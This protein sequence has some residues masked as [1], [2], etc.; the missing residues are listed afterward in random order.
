MRRPYPLP[1]GRV[2]PRGMCV[3]CYR[4]LGV[5]TP[6]EIVHHVV[7]LN[8]SNISDPSVSLSQGN[9]MRVCRDCHAKIHYPDRFEQRVRFD[10]MGRVVPIGR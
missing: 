1:G 3:M 8:E 5:L 10:S 2:V 6:A 4:D 7:W 9:L